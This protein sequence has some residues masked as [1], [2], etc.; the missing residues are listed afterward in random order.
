MNSS[1]LFYWHKY[2]AYNIFQCVESWLARGGSTEWRRKEKIHDLGDWPAPHTFNNSR[3][4]THYSAH[5]RVLTTG[6]SNGSFRDQI[7]N[8]FGH[9]WAKS[10]SSKKVSYILTRHGIRINVGQWSCILAKDWALYRPVLFVVREN[11]IWETFR[12][13]PRVYWKDTHRKQLKRDMLSK[14]FSLGSM[15]FS[16]N[17]AVSQQVI[18]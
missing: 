2:N 18:R 5:Q 6:C 1:K 12:T 7:Y 15:K 16:L 9:R 13:V 8:N 3:K 4:V 10:I 11:R 14:A 17:D